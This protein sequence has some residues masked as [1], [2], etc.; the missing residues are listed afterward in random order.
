[1][2]KGGS[3]EGGPKEHQGQHAHYSRGPSK[4]LLVGFLGFVGKEGPLVVHLQ[5]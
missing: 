1:M 5:T 3:S 4:V 2:G